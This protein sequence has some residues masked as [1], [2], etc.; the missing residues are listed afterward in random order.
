M[1]IVYA[2]LLLVPLNIELQN[3]KSSQSNMQVQSQKVL[4][5][6]PKK[7]D[8]TVLS[9]SKLDIV[10]KK[11]ER[12]AYSLPPADLQDLTPLPAWFRV[13][14]R[15]MNPNLPTS[16]SY[17]YPRTSIRLLQYLVSNPENVELPK[18]SQ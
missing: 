16:G 1:R 9:G 8:V 10:K 12:E 14:L 7:W 2:M 17:Q 6:Y 3:N 4:A 15:K 11:M 18:N 13:Y 5:Q